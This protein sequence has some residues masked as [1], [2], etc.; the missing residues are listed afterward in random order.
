M[1]TLFYKIVKKMV[2]WGASFVNI[3][4]V[5]HRYGDPKDDQPKDIYPMW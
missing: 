1:K 2:A 4:R 5:K 3:F